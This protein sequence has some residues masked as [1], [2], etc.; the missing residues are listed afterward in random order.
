[1]ESGPIAQRRCWMEMTDDLNPAGIF[2]WTITV[3]KFEPFSAE[4]FDEIDGASQLAIVI[5]SDG[6]RFAIFAR[7]R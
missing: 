3:V 1:M 7:M 2:P 6:N 5:A 4:G